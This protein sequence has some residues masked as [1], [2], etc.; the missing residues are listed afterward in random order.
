MTS[1]MTSTMKSTTSTTLMP[2][3]LPLT[4]LDAIVAL[5]APGGSADTRNRMPLLP[6]GTKAART[7]L[8]VL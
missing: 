1:T 8:E 4:R 5:A 7:N 2:A 3:R 6:P